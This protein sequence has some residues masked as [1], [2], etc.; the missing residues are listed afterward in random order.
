MSAIPHFVKY[1]HDLGDVLSSPLIRLVSDGMNNIGRTDFERTDRFYAS[2][3]GMCPRQA[4]LKSQGKGEIDNPASFNAYCELGNTIEDLVVKSLER[5]KALLF[6]QYRIPDIGINLGGKIDVIAVVKGKLRI[7]EVKSCGELP[8]KEAKA[9][10]QAQALIY[11]AVTGLPASV[12]YF[13]RNVWDFKDNKLMLK[14][15]PLDDMLE[16]KR[17][18]IYRASLAYYSTRK[19]YLP[20]I[21]SHIMKKSDCGFCPF[22]SFC[23]DGLPLE[24]LLKSPTPEQNDTVIQ[25]AK[26]F[27]D[28]L[29][30]FNVTSDRRRGIL[31]H[32][33]MSGGKLAQDVLRGSW[34]DLL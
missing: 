34:D 8:K 29:L 14:E 25:Q 22:K 17:A 9:E 3:A 19:G 31:K 1:S 5:E 30:D 18:V 32:I 4:A 26:A 33:Q 16:E 15:I 23:W 13:S 7:I 11:S 21:P 12:L 20:D 2:D 27:T 24:T 28:H 10:H 6:T